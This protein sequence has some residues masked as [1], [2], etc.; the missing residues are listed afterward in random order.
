MVS[1]DPFLGRHES[2]SALQRW[3]L[4]KLEYW[5]LADMLIGFHRGRLVQDKATRE[6][7]LNC[8]NWECGVI[9]PIPAKCSELRDGAVA[10]HIET[11]LTAFTGHVP[12]P[13]KLPSES[14][15]KKTPWTNF[16][17]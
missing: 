4:I 2:F 11:G 8:R 12:V 10:S 15:L 13:M 9:M 7:R 6:P 1:E 3:T 16:Q 17:G 14:M 5:I